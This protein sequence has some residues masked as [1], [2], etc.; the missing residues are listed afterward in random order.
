V[1]ADESFGAELLKRELLDQTQLAYA[2]QR[3]SVVGESLWKTVIHAGLASEAQVARVLA[4][5]RGYLYLPPADLPDSEAS[6]L[7]MFSRDLCLAHNF[8]PLGRNGTVME[9]VLGDADPATVEETVAQRTSLRCSFVVSEFSQVRRLIVHRFHFSQHPPETLLDAQVRVIA[10]D[11]ARALSPENLLDALLHLAVRERAS[12][13]HIVPTGVT[14]HVLFRVDGVLRP[15]RALPPALSRLIG[16]V[17]LLAEMDIS[18]QRLPQD[19]SL[20]RVILDENTTIRVSTIVTEYGERMV[21]RLL[22]EAY[23]QKGLI[24]LGYF[25]EDVLAICQRMSSPS[26]LVL[27]TGPT[28]SGKSS[29]LHAGLRMQRLIERNVLTVEDPL[30]YRVPGAGQTEVN[31]RAGYDFSTALRHFLRHD[32]DVILVGEMRDAETAQ[33][34]IAAAATGHLVLSTL[35]ITTV[36]GIVPRLAPFGISAP[37]IA[38]NLL[39]VIN[40]RLVRRNCPHCARRM[41]WTDEERERLD[42]GSDTQAIRCAG[43]QSCRGSGY[44]GRL[45]IYEILDVNESVGNAIAEGCSRERLKEVASNSGFEP[46]F[47]NARRRILLGQT[48]LE[49]VRRSIGGEA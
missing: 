43:C 35:H 47:A 21:M 5:V 2:L 3:N 23:D 20:R 37:L 26:G 28:G 18:E 24:D 34:A 42:P 4:D 9:V 10:E 40:Q 16:Y 36:F 25:T 39:L 30:E 29:T 19:G 14:Y 49:E 27:V 46:I 11:H 48:T 8:L 31:R 41:P 6:T 12:D 45:P 1:K 15:V 22:P 13:V 7:A 17:K 38:E 44:L 32:P 33:A